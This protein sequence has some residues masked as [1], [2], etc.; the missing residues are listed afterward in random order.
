MKLAENCDTATNYICEIEAGKKF[1]S[2]EMIEKIAQALQIQP[3]LLFFDEQQIPA[4]PLIAR[5]IKDDIARQIE[6]SVQG[7]LARY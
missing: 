5:K 3:Y 2:V 4:V 1:P 7:I 6:L